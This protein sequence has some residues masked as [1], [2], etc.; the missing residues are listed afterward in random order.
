MKRSTDCFESLLAFLM[1][2]HHVQLLPEE[3]RRVALMAGLQAIGI[4]TLV[5]LG[6]L[7]YQEGN[8]GL[9]YSDFSLAF[10]LALNT[11]HARAFGYFRVNIL[12]GM[13]ATAALYIYAFLT[14]GVNNSGFVWYYTFPLISFYLLGSRVGSWAS[15]L[16]LFPA[17]W[18]FL[19]DASH[20]GL[21]QYSAD[22]KYRFIPSY[23]VVLAFSYFFERSRELTMAELRQAQNDL[24]EKVNRKTEELIKIN[25][26]LSEEVHERRK[27]ENIYRTLVETI[28]HG[29][30]EIDTDGRIL[31]SN[32]IHARIYGYDVNELSGKTIQDFVP[33]RT[34]QEALLSY[35]HHLA[36]TSP[37]PQ[38]WLNTNIRRDG[39]MIDVQVDWNYRRDEH[40]KVTGFVAIVSDVTERNRA[41]AELVRSE[42][43]YR[44]LIE[45]INIG[46]VLYEVTADEQGKPVNLVFREVNQTFAKM[47]QI[48]AQDVIGKPIGE[49]LSGRDAAPEWL[50]ACI[51]VATTGQ[52]AA[53]EYFCPTFEKW[54]SVILY[55]PWEN[56]VAA[57]IRDITDLKLAE[58]QRTRDRNLESLGF[59]A[60]GIA[61]DFNNL[62]MAVFGNIDLAM[63]KLPPESPAH[64]NLFEAVRGME[65]A[66]QLTGQL[67]T[68]SRGGTPSRERVFITPLLR[69]T[70]DFVLS[71]SKIRTQYR[72]PAD[73]WPAQVDRAQ[74]TQVFSNLIMNAREA[75]P[76]GGTLKITAENRE[77]LPEVDSGITGPWVRISMADTGPGIPAEY[78]DS[79]FDPYFSTKH[80]GQERG[81]GLGLAICHSIVTRHGG[82]ISCSSSEVGTRFDID[83]PAEPG[84]PV[85][86]K[87]SSLSNQCRS[88]EQGRILLMEDEEDVSLIAQSMLEHLGYQVT[89]VREGQAA[90]SEY[91]KSMETAPAFDA[92]ILD[93]TIRGGMG[94]EETMAEL[95]KVNPDVVAVVS[96]GYADD[97][98]ISSFRDFG[99]R[100]VL[101][102]PYV[103]DQLAGV[104]SSI[105][106]SDRK[107]SIR[108]NA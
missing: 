8:Y 96:S 50:R 45:N 57:L 90:L 93:L 17:I 38:P 99:F 53:L 60:G 24:E 85:E 80:A 10:I 16:I 12:I 81:R 3:R 91:R 51:P 5:P 88:G 67:R 73:L 59:L 6:S 76:D 63:T 7:A 106:D 33:D 30:C 32:A 36:V 42:K 78:L 103:L 47:A 84:K 28:P 87:S 40:G 22:F 104:L 86:D 39:R 107:D 15:S 26:R 82:S 13:C 64:Q 2:P 72:F 29:I 21:A 75:M 19:S 55:S 100:A 101:P 52:G 48:P 4:V 95:L 69:E 65:R 37:P 18:L 92:V 14:G 35:L 46:F 70:A 20:P 61:H 1:G 97:P 58:S 74:F 49:V 31:F 89:W 94:G 54:L 44:A 34:G 41:Y 83:L 102:K 108:G 79:I 68:F 77:S 98:V 27:A 66:T 56:Y 62:L 71:G 11:L 43:R 25:Q 23:L 9:A 105:R